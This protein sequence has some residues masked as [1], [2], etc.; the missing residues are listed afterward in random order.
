MAYLTTLDNL[1][2]GV[3]EFCGVPEYTLKS[4]LN[5]SELDLG[6]ENALVNF[7][8]AVWEIARDKLGLEITIG[9]EVSSDN[10]T[11]IKAA[12]CYEILARLYHRTAKGNKESN[13]WHEAEYNHDQF[14]RVLASVPVEWDQSGTTS[15]RDFVTVRLGR[16]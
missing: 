15:N 5:K 3:G 8:R 1:L 16:A 2:N 7:H 14:L 11:R 9:S 4:L 12:C 13:S 6:I 10:Q